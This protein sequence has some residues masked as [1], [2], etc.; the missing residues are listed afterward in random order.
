MRSNVTRS[1]PWLLALCVCASPHPACAHEDFADICHA[2]SSYDL[3]IAPAS[4]QFDRANPA[5]R[6][7]DLHNGKLTLDGAVLRLN[8][9]DGDRLVAFEQEL[10][11][12]L[13]RVKVV[14]GKGVDLAIKAVREALARDFHEAQTLDEFDRVLTTRGA[15]L[16]RRIAAST[17]TRDWQGD[18]FDRYA[19]EIAADVAPLL[20]TAVAREAAAAAQNGDLSV[21][22]E[23]S[24]GL[25]AGLMGG[26]DLAQRLE[27]PMQPLRPQIEALCP[28]LR[29]LAELQR[30]VRDAKGR[31]LDLLE[32][33]GR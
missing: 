25:V 24:G 27:G 26:D 14:A 3:T 7:V 12:L 10:R 6:R 1:K 19:N 4:L 11:A 8:T 5:P 29:R 33:E 2:S 30:G 15:D 28:S 23:R 13:P 17:S 32:I 31:P 20:A 16:K 21:L 18:T 22:R 9:E